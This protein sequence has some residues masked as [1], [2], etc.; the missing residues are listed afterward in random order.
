MSP[1]YPLPAGP[2]TGPWFA[3]AEFGKYTS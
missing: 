1:V 2:K 3:S